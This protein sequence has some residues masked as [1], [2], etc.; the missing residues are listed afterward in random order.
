[1]AKPG[2]AVRE[3]WAAGAVVNGSNP[4]RMRQEDCWITEQNPHIKRSNN[5]KDSELE[6][7]LSISPV[8]AC[9]LCS[10]IQLAEQGGSSTLAG[11]LRAAEH[12]PQQKGEV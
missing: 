5:N 1:M 6:F 12:G 7:G 4:G 11:V 10:S 9:A 2:I 8:P 3:R